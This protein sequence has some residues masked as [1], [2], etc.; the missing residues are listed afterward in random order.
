MLTLI[1]YLYRNTK[2][3]KIPGKAT[4]FKDLTK[5]KTLQYPVKILLRPP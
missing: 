4:E 3:S 5:T 2:T 1:E